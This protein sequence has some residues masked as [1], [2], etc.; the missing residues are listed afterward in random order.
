MSLRII[1][2]KGM[3]AANW[4]NQMSLAFESLGQLPAVRADADWKP[5]ARVVVAQIGLSAFTPPAPDKYAKWEDWAV[6]FNKATM[7]LGV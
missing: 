5:W 6:E 4:C 1:Y 3:S 7:N 2:P